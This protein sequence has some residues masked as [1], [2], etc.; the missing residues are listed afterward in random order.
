RRAAAGQLAQRFDLVGEG[1]VVRGVKGLQPK[2]EGLSR[3]LPACVEVERRP[4]GAQ[5]CAKARVQLDD[6]AL[7]HLV[8]VD[9]L[10]EAARIG[11]PPHFD[12]DR[13]LQANKTF[14]Q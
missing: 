3:Q 11:E 2:G 4:A 6:V 9:V 1:L 13:L 12:G 14:L 7:R 5:Q 8:P 10:N